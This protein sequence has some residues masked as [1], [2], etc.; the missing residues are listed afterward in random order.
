[1]SDE[2]LMQA[3]REAERDSKAWLAQRRYPP[4]PALILTWWDFLPVYLESECD[5]AGST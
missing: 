4:T 5:G 1:M 3:I 2:V